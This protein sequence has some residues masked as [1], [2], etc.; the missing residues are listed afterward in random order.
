MNS[1][2]YHFSP[3]KSLDEKNFYSSSNLRMIV[4]PKCGTMYCHQLSYF[5]Q[6]SGTAVVAIILV[7][8]MLC[9]ICNIQTELLLYHGIREHADG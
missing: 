8:I 1:R 3:T 5:F 4:A 7:V 9:Y 6:K 2:V